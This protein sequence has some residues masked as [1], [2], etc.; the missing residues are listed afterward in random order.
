MSTNIGYTTR[1]TGSV[2]VVAVVAVVA[3]V[4]D[5]GQHMDTR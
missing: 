3:V 5:S 1:N 2:R 4:L